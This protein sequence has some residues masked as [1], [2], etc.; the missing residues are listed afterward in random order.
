MHGMPLNMCRALKHSFFLQH[1]HLCS[2]KHKFKCG[3]FKCQQ[4]NTELTLVFKYFSMSLNQT[5]SRILQTCFRHHRY[6]SSVLRSRHHSFTVSHGV[7]AH[8]G[9]DGEPWML[10][11]WVSL[12]VCDQHIS[13]RLCRLRASL[14]VISA[15]KCRKPTKMCRVP[16]IQKPHCHCQQGKDQHSHQHCSRDDTMMQT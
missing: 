2:F 16:L 1:F 3:L 6:L 8:L 10:F 14:S 13:I 7:H 5:A 12:Q 4:R 9:P 15:A 11:S